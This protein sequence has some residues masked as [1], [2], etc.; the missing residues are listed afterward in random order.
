MSKTK[1]FCNA[2]ICYRADKLNNWLA[3]NPVL[4]AGEKAIITDGKVGF[5]EKV[6]DGVTAFD[7]LP[8][9]YENGTGKATDAGGEIHNDYNYNRAD[10]PNSSV[11]GSNNSCGKK[12]F[13]IY[14]VDLPNKTIELGSASGLAEGDVCSAFFNVIN[15]SGQSRCNEYEYFGKVE[16]IQINQRG[17][18]NVRFNELPIS[19]DAQLGYGCFIWVP[20][21]KN[22]GDYSIGN[23]AFTIGTMNLSLHDNSFAG[24]IDS[25]ALGPSSFSFGSMTRANGEYSAAFGM[26]THT[27]TQAQ[28]AIGK[29]NALPEGALL[30]VGNG[31]Y[32]IESNALTVFGDGSAK[33]GKTGEDDT[34]V[35]TK[36]YVDGTGSRLVLDKT[37]YTTAATPFFFADADNSGNPLCIRKAKVVFAF[38]V[39]SGGVGQLKILSDSDTLAYLDSKEISSGKVY[40]IAL[41]VALYPTLDGK[42]IAVS[43]YSAVPSECADFSLAAPLGTPKKQSVCTV[44]SNF[45]QIG[46]EWVNDTVTDYRIMIWE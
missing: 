15:Q 42:F 4:L 14:S 44:N 12:G 21:K 29:Y 10:A 38:K 33:I 43:E 27:E 20:N 2:R 23:S 3:E 46:V 25:R 35:A 6:G 11:F 13:N 16:A 45:S 37:V 41:D 36:G 1:I 19:Q 24:G 26:G 9:S 22:I 39:L 18:Y 40:C 8:F 5:R 30:C 28:M 17:T 31:D 32:G 7:K 34:S